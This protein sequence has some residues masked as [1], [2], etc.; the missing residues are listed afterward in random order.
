MMAST[1]RTSLA[2]WIVLS[3]SSIVTMPR[4]SMIIF[5]ET[6]VA[7]TVLFL[8]P[9][10]KRTTVSAAADNFSST[11]GGVLTPRSCHSELPFGVGFAGQS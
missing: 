5:D 11:A 6:V 7:G 8:I 2:I 4:S 3:Q 1:C 9:F 10:L